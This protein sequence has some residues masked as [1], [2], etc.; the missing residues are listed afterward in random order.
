MKRGQAALSVFLLLAVL[1]SSAPAQEKQ[2]SPVAR[3][4]KEALADLQRKPNDPIIQ[5]RYL[6]AFPRDYKSFLELFDFERELSDGYEYIAILLMLSKS[7]EREVGILLVQLGGDAHYEADAPGYL[8]HATSIYGSEHTQMFVRFLK[9]LPT[10]KQAQLIAF[11]ADVE[12]PAAY[13]EYQSIID[14][15]KILGDND[16]AHK[17]EVAREKRASE[18]NN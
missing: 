17:F 10:G 6:L 9:R 3:K 4:L 15:L 14:H 16:V 1:S 7:H 11:L 5:K 12:N 13:P 8:Q 18:P 2:L